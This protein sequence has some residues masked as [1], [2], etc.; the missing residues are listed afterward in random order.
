M[1]YSD[2]CQAARFTWVLQP[3]WVFVIA[4]A[5]SSAALTAVLVAMAAPVATSFMDPPPKPVPDPSRPKPY[6][7]WDHIP[8]AFHGANRSRCLTLISLHSEPQSVTH[9]AFCSQPDKCTLSL[10]LGM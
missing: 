1:S 8:Q 3:A 4:V 5:G 10:I 2:Y 6:F 9:I 7:S